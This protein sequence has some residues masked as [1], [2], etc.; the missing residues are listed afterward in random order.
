MNV[1]S[2]KQDFRQTML[3]GLTIDS[4]V[5]NFIWHKC[6]KNLWRFAVIDKIIGIKKVTFLLDH[7]VPVC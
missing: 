3:G 4:P 7:S 1:N 6:A 5:A 2:H